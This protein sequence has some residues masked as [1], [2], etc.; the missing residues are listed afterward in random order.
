MSGDCGVT[1]GVTVASS[2]D[3]GAVVVGERVDEV[4]RGSETSTPAASMLAVVAEGS[5]TKW[6]LWDTTTHRV[7]LCSDVPGALLSDAESQCLCVIADEPSHTRHTFTK[8]VLSLHSF[9]VLFC[10]KT[11][12]PMPQTTAGGNELRE[13]A[14]ATGVRDNSDAFVML[15]EVLERVSALAP[16]LTIDDIVQEAQKTQ[17]QQDGIALNGS[18]ATN[19][20]TATEAERD[21]AEAAAAEAAAA[22]AA[23]M[24]AAA[25]T[26]QN[27]IQPSGTYQ[28]NG[29]NATRGSYVVRVRGLGLK[30]TEAD[31]SELFAPL[32]VVSAAMVGTRECHPSYSP[33]EG[34]VEF[35]T[36]E[37]AQ[38]ALLKN[39]EMH[40]GHQV[41]VQ[42][43]SVAER[44][45]V[46]QEAAAE[47]ART[48]QLR[49]L[50]ARM[51]GQDR[52][53]RGFLRLRGLPFDATVDDVLAFFEGYDV[54]R[55]REGVPGADARGVPS[56]YILV[57]AERRPEGTAYVEFEKESVALLASNARNRRSMGRRYIELFVCARAE[58]LEALEQQLE[59]ALAATADGGTTVRLRGLPW[60]ASVYDIAAF[61]APLRIAP[62][63]V[64]IVLNREGRP[65]G[66]GFV[67]F[68]TA[69]D[70]AAALLRS[71]QSMDRRYIEVFRA[72][73]QE[74]AAAARHFAD[75]ADHHHD[76]RE[77]P[78]DSYGSGS[79][80]S[81]SRSGR[82]Y[83]R[84]SRMPPGGYAQPPP[85]AGAGGYMAPYP[86]AP[87]GYVPSQPP[88][89]YVPQ[90]AMPMGQQMMYA[91]PG[92]YLAPQSMGQYYQPPVPMPP[93]SQQ[94]QQHSQQPQMQQQQQMQQQGT[95][96]SHQPP[97]PQRDTG[98]SQC[99]RVWNLPTTAGQRD[100][101]NV[102]AGYNYSSIRM[103][104]DE[105][106]RWCATIAFKTPE[107]AANAITAKHMSFIGSNRICVQPEPR[108]N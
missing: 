38:Q 22:T 19:T 40:K 82:R 29:S 10:T 105:Q 8:P 85:Y 94:Q 65:S 42:Q 107:E 57:N 84:D 69:E 52:H 89:Q 48:E 72:T 24:A 32:A 34:F 51:R 31:L 49:A 47:T 93:Q 96:Q 15:S 92:M 21:A 3:A 71:R 100:L 7:T 73:Q 4:G 41:E 17:Q 13:A 77:R 55:I 86:P 62:D 12:V 36:P 35:G 70:A 11:G 66:E 83:D 25:T 67:R 104:N 6:A 26:P 18:S 88:Q 16:N 33:A 44:N 101:E 90:Y 53:Y 91:Q 74:V 56:V 54:V 37:A 75:R 98:A 1:E 80:S 103:H 108:Q 60:R 68:E 28:G 14:E 58:A 50:V 2:G 20:S 23:A 30:A 81:S 106:G 79:S 27:Q 39:A 102:F 43:S 45:N 63:G 61:F 9:C 59:R 95:P 99:V 97:Q 87:G 46:L 78:Y 76:R 5:E 64:H